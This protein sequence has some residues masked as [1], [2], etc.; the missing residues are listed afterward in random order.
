M[1]G[2]RNL[3]MA[4]AGDFDGDCQ[5]EL[6]VPDQQRNNLAGVQHTA[7]GAEQDWLL[8]LG[9]RLSSNLMAVELADGQI[10]VGAGRWEKVLRLWL[11][12]E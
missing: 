3:D 10:V 12:E 2:S 7:G 4:V 5:V 9:G 11:P 1:L 6:L 8:P